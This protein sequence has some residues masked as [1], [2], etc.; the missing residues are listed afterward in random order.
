MNHNVRT[1]K[2]I[3]RWGLA[4][5][6]FYAAIASLRHPD[7]WVAYFPNFLRTALS[8]HLLIVIVSVFEMALAAWLFWGKKLLWSAGLSIITLAFIIIFNLGIFD[9]VFRDIGLLFA[10]LALL[11]LARDA[12][13]NKLNE[14]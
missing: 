10:A 11:E 3:L 1:A 13:S 7:V 9:I 2:V 4:F 14:E 8:E 12:D 5:I 6:F